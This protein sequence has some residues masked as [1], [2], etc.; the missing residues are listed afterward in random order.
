MEGRIIREQY[1]VVREL[2]SEPGFS[3]VQAVDIRERQRPGCL[4][5]LY[6]GDALKRWGRLLA[7]IRREDCPQFRCVFLDGEKRTLAAV[8]EDAK[9]KPFNLLLARGKKLERGER[10][11]WMERLL[12][13]ALMLNNLPT[14]L[15][16]DALLPENVLVDEEEG[17]L[18]LR[19]VLPP[20]SPADP[21]RVAA[22]HALALYPRKY[23]R[24][25]AEDELL[26]ALE[27]CDFASLAELY[28]FWR[29]MSARIDEEYAEWMSR[30]FLS[31]WW[32]QL[33]RAARRKA[34][35]TGAALEAR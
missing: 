13:A 16:S 14:E 11:K 21:V 6:E 3:A 10:L 19:F 20:I 4:L 26:D 15:A 24:T 12:H 1:K 18:E 9:G 33:K 32:I 31:R 34:A 29:R 17:S 22:D 5:N 23:G 25:D 7:D 27:L 35:A 30:S 2:V 28:S 8:F